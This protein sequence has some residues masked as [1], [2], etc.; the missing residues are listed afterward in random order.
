MWAGGYDGTIRRWSL[1]LRNER[2]PL[3]AHEGIVS[4]LLMLANG[5]VVSASSTDKALALWS[6]RGELLARLSSRPLLCMADAGEFLWCCSTSK[7]V[8][9][10]QKKGEGLRLRKE[11]VLPTSSPGRCI[12][13]VGQQLWIG[14]GCALVMYDALRLKLTMVVEAAHRDLVTAIAFGSRLIYTASHDQTV[15]V[16][17]FDGSE[18]KTLPLHSDRVTALCVTRDML[19]SG[20][21]DHSIVAYALHAQEVVAT[22]TQSHASPLSCLAFVVTPEEKKQELWSVSHDAIIHIK[23]L[24]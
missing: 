9:V 23:S 24:D 16:W 17:S 5:S 14:S 13:Q 1:L 19:F 10:R 4:C 21:A 8:Q 7:V 22:D 3:Q 20:S 18:G 2:P 12:L 15:K 11:L 6:P